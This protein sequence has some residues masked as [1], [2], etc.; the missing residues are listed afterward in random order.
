MID[1]LNVADSCKRLNKAAKLV[2]A[3]KYRN[4]FVGLSYIKTS[5]DR[6]YKITDISN[7]SINWNIIIG[8]L[9]TSLQLLRCVGHM[10]FGIELNAIDN[11]LTNRLFNGVIA[12]Y[13]ENRSEIDRMLITYI[14]KYCAENLK[15]F[16][17][18][19]HPSTR[20]SLS[21]FDLLQYF[22]KSLTNVHTFYS[23]DYFFTEKSCLKKLFPNLVRLKFAHQS[24]NASFHNINTYN[25][26]NLKQ[27]SIK[28]N[29][30]NSS[31]L[32]NEMVLNFL[33]LNPQLRMFRL[34]SQSYF[35]GKLNTNLVRSA[36]NSLQNIEKIVLDIKPITFI[37][38]IIIHMKNVREFGIRFDKMYEFPL[39]FLPFSFEKLEKFMI[40]FPSERNIGVFNREFYNFIN[41]H[42]TITNLSIFNIERCSSFVDWPRLA[43]SL[44]FLAEITLVSKP[45]S[46]DEAIEILSYFQM[47]NKF[48]FKLKGKYDDFRIQL[49]EI[50]EGTYKEADKSVVLKRIN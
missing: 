16:S 9:K 24:S 36:V 46:S 33:Q 1:L 21:Q 22:D 11:S 39:C 48:Q 29:R 6:L 3:S 14:N 30:S 40:S 5:P 45:I 10:V 41:K 37:N 12:R 47:L 8:D 34:E 49:D 28:E 15:V 38:S 27:L 7:G 44:P 13:D 19:S 18:L 4:K 26:P 23:F 50:W 20:D 43:E 17:I 32:E 25:F 31:I 35:F 2:Y 42:S